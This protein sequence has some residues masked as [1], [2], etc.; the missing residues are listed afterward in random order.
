MKGKE[1]GG[2]KE[3]AN[4]GECNVLAHL[5]L[6]LDVGFLHTKVMK[7]ILVRFF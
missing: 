6:A 5:A 4:G 3:G 2:V 1:I 7:K